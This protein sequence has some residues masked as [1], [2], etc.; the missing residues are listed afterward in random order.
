MSTT[1]AVSIA[2]LKA[3]IDAG[4]ILN[5]YI[6]ENDAKCF[7][8]M[9]SSVTGQEHLLALNGEQPTGFNTLDDAARLMQSQGVSRIYL[10]MLEKE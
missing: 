2:E 9:C 8:V 7:H 3:L 5:T 1:H 4:S 10:H 6:I